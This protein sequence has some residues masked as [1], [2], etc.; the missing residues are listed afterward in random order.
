MGQQ[1]A[2]PGP[3]IRASPAGALAIAERG[4]ALLVEIPT[5]LLLLAEV[6]ILFMGVAARYVFHTPL[7]WSDEL[8]SIL[9]LWLAMFGSAVALQRTS[10]MRLSYAVDRLPPL[11]RA[12]AEAL[13]IG[14]PL[15]FVALLISPAWDYADDQ[16]FIETPALGW[17]GLVRALAMPV[18]FGL[19]GLSGLV[20]LARF[21]LKAILLAIAMLA[22][23]AGLLFLAAPALHAM[24]NWNLLVF[25][26]LLLGLAVIAGMPIAFGFAM[27]TVAYL[28]ATT[29]TPLSIVVGRIDEGHELADPAGRAALRPARPVD[30]DDGHGARAGQFP[31]GPCGACPWRAVLR[32]DWR[33]LARLRHQRVEDG[34][35]GGGGPGA[36][37]GNEAPRGE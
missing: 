22:V 18:G 10:H 17:S 2:A 36:V 34:G 35:H 16:S 33:H 14:V 21:P 25:F 29:S 30:G 32:A 3:A 5:I 26:V 9:F 13:A 31:G 19:I 27:A 4:L 23:L 15:L 1:L 6:V 37:P 7:I 12:V 20:Q 11:A 28:L 24:G 8:A